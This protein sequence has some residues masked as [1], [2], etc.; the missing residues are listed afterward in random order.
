[1]SNDHIEQELSH[2]LATTDAYLE[3]YLPR[4]RAYLMAMPEVRLA[5]F[6]PD[7]TM[8]LRISGPDHSRV[9][10][11]FTRNVSS[12]H[13]DKRLGKIRRHFAALLP[14]DVDF[15]DIEKMDNREACEIAFNGQSL[16]GSMEMVEQDRLYRY[17]VF[18]EW[19]AGKKLSGMKQD[20]PPVLQPS[21]DQPLRIVTVDHFITPI[22]RHLKMIAVQVREMERLT[23]MELSDFSAENTDSRRPNR[24]CSRASRARY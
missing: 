5:Y 1:M 12:E 19:N 6:S 15:Q 24:T 4:I 21:F 18:L 22:Y 20:Q 8:T 3:D 13:I 11:A 17:N 10:M 9:V 14:E 7:R 16:Y 2:S 23:S